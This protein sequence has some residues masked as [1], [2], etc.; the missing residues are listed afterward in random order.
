LVYR[1]LKDELISWEEFEAFF[2]AAG[3]CEANGA[4]SAVQVQEL[5][6]DGDETHLKARTAEANIRGSRSGTLSTS[7]AHV[8]RVTYVVE[9]CV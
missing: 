5:N 6:D 2:I 7:Q 3:W 8:S 9:K 4:R 1:T